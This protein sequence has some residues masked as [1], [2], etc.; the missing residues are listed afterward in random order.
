MP[1][2][3]ILSWCRTRH[4][5]MT[6]APVNADAVVYTF[7][8]MM[9]IGGP[10]TYRWEGIVDSVEATGEYSVRFTLGQSFRAIPVQ[11]LFHM[12]FIVNPATVEANRGDDFGASYSAFTTSAGSGPFTSRAVGKSVTSTS[13]I[14]CSMIIGVGRP[15]NRHRRLHLDHPA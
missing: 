4:S 15:E 11:T 8:R 13:S 1:A 14:A 10:P 7:N 12:L 9:E 6:A 5:M 3:G 2:S